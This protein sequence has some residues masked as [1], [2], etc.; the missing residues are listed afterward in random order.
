[1]GELHVGRDIL[2]RQ[3]TLQEILHVVH[4]RHDVV[5]R[6]ARIGDRQQVVQVYAVHAGPAQMIGDEFRSTRLASAF[7]PAR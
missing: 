3:R 6:F 4:T 1:M 5:Q 7:S 2:D